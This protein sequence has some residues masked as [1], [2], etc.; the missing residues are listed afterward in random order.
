MTDGPEAARYATAYNFGPTEDDARP[1]A[2]IADRMT[3]FW[4]DGAS[5]V[6]DEDP[7]SPHEATYLKLDASRAR[8]DLHWAPQLRLETALEWLVSWYRAWQ[9]APETMQSVTLQQIAAY[10]RLLEGA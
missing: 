7:N 4:G 2:W 6:L 8:H 3:R 9:S 10:Q 5:W 1:V